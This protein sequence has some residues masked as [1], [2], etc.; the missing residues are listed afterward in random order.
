M[1]ELLMLYLGLWVFV[2]IFKIFEWLPTPSNYKPKI[3]NFDSNFE[4]D[5]NCPCMC[6]SECDN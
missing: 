5:H 3:V 2:I 4:R 1:F 6:E